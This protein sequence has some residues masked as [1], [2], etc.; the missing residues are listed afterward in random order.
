MSNELKLL[1]YYRQFYVIIKIIVDAKVV[2][3]KG[4]AEKTV[5]DKG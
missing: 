5:G 1:M 4:F 2:R 3:A